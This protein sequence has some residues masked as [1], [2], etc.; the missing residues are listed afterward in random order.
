M[1]TRDKNLLSDQDLHDILQNMI[2]GVV[3]VNQEGI[4]TY[5]NEAAKEFLEDPDMEGRFFIREDY[6]LLNGEGEEV[7]VEEHPVSLSLKK[8]KKITNFIQLLNI[9]NKHKWFSVNTSP[10]RNDDKIDGAIVNFVE[11]TEEVKA[12]NQLKESEKKYRLLAENMTDAILLQEKDGSY[13]YISESIE[14]ILGYST[15]EF[16]EADPSDL[17]HPDDLKKLE[18]SHSDVLD[19][20]ANTIRY[21]SKSKNGEYKWLESHVKLVEYED[22]KHYVQNTVR[23]IHEQKILEDRLRNREQQFGKLLE[24]APFII[25][26]FDKEG[27]L[28]ETNKAWEKTWGLR[29]SDTVGWYNILEDKNLAKYGLKE[30]AAKGLAGERGGFTNAFYSHKL[31]PDLRKYFDIRY[32][33]LTNEEGEI[34]NLV[35][36]SDDVTEKILAEKRLRDSENKF[37]SLFESA[38]HA[39][40]IAEPDG[41]IREVNNSAAKIFGLPKNELKKKNALELTHPD[42]KAIVS[43]RFEKLQ[44]GQR[45]NFVL[46]IR[47][48]DKDGQTKWVHLSASS[49]LDSNDKPMVVLILE[50]ISEKQ[51]YLQQVK[52]SELKFRSIFEETGHGITIINSQGTILSANKRFRQMIGLSK[53][54][55][56]EGA[57]CLDYMSYSTLDEARANFDHLLSHPSESVN[58][59]GKLYNKKGESL[60]VRLNGSAY[61]DPVTGDMHMVGIVEDISDRKIVVEK[62]KASE[63][64]QHETINALHVGL[65]VM[66]TNGE[67]EQINAAWQSLIK[68]WQELKNIGAGDNFIEV[69]KSLSLGGQLLSGI[70]QVTTEETDLF[71]TEILTGKKSNRWFAIR[72]SKLTAKFDCLVIT[73]QDITIRKKVEKA[74]EESLSSYRN[75]Y[76]KTPV[77]MHSIDQHGTLVSVSDF[78]LEKMGYQRH[79]VIGRK[80]SDFLSED[81]KKDSKV[82]MPV[83]FDRGSIYDVSYKFITRYGEVLETLLSAIEE[84]RG[85]ENS[86]SLAVVTDITALKKA[87]RDLKKSQTALLEA[88]SLARV[89]NYDLNI[90]TGLFTSSKVFDEILEIEPADEKHFSLLQ[91][92]ISDEHFEEVEKLFM[93]SFKTAGH[94][95]YSGQCKTLRSKTNI[96]LEGIGNVIMKDGQPD[97]LVGTIQDVTSGKEAEHEIQKLTERLKMAMQAAGIGVWEED[98][99]T[100][101]LHWEPEMYELFQLDPERPVKGWNEIEELMDEEDRHKISDEPD[102]IQQGQDLYYRDFKA[103]L[104]DGLHHLRSITREIKNSQNEAVRLVGVVMDVS[105]DKEILENLEASLAEK[106][107]LLKEVHHRVKNNMQMIS[108][109]LALKSMEL[110]DPDAKST[111]DDCTSRVKSMAMVHDQ[112]YK[113]YNLSEIEMG[114]YLHHLIGGL[115][116]LLAGSS[117][118][119]VLNIDADKYEMDVDEALLCGLMV[120]EIVANAFK[121]G[122]KGRKEGVIDVKFRLHPDKKVLTITNT[123][124][125]MPEDVLEI[126]TSSLGMSLIKT[127]SSQLGGELRRHEDNGLQITF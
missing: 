95:K 103:H 83:F 69:I 88:Q 49:F 10:A 93:D 115:N 42:D 119:F 118:D 107:T 52:A 104:P 25:Q 5:A 46:E 75:I 87:E 27:T 13:A 102:R 26:I 108:S 18:K 90:H 23:D 32:F 19:G 9:G 89:G 35:V 24:E 50:D 33:P 54:D 68:N 59:E 41:H 79:E 36:I 3:K 117:G 110:E 94:F 30:H 61:K 8:G 121:H 17:F 64:F 28:V 29:K 111:F 126:K 12:Q 96:W 99:N 91:H 114:E 15:S 62:L 20:K 1:A 56:K 100:G 86:R 97:R 105:R 77:M 109:I 40:L 81:S 38:G 70:H 51:E 101:R 2:V 84:G 39:I 106:D 127:F 43:S 92:V 122:F 72:A 65:M 45:K 78:W 82:V 7:P 60:W 112:L 47:C 98:L 124:N 44:T 71:E 85:T 66:R 22:G 57:N 21:R 116:A 14:E 58:T 48:I 113:F 6:G 73:L 55:I 125:P 120:S 74:L 16:S 123:G 76:N 67:I 4:I 11:I 53:S 80:L 63:E 37:R 34:E 31:Y